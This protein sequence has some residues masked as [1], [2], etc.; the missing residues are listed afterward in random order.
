MVQDFMGGGPP[1]ALGQGGV[2][3]HPPAQATAMEQAFPRDHHASREVRPVRRCGFRMARGHDQAAF[4]T[5]PSMGS[6][7]SVS[8]R[9]RSRL[10]VGAGAKTDRIG[11]EAL[12]HAPGLQAVSAP[13]PAGG[14]RR[15]RAGRKT[16]TGERVA[17]GN[18][19]K[20]LRVA[21]GVGG[22]EP[23][24]RARRK[25]LEQLRTEDGRDLPRHL[26]VQ[27]RRKP[28]RLALLL[29]QIKAVE[30]EGD[31][32]LAP[33]SQRRAARPGRAAAGDPGDRPGS[34]HAGAVGGALS[35][36]RQPKAGG[37]L[38]APP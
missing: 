30:A 23:L 3:R 15:G 16:L 17:H 35:P 9:L 13:S 28:D 4:V 22:C 36:L 2:L 14:A 25:R 19:I 8:I 37:R 10:H 11:G 1:P 6:A 34:R 18:R 21:Q 26:R 38:C 27:I 12:V 24:R 33:A 32:E 20:G 5:M 7:S 29:A 31:A